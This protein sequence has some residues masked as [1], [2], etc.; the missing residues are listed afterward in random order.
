MT[1]LFC[2]VP[3]RRKQNGRSPCPRME[4]GRAEAMRRKIQ[5]TI[6]IVENDAS[7]AKRSIALSNRSHLEAI[8][9]DWQREID[10]SIVDSRLQT[11]SS[12]DRSTR[13][14][15]KSGSSK[16]PQNS[17]EDHSS[18]K[19]SILVGESTSW[20]FFFCTLKDHAQL[21]IMHALHTERKW[22]GWHEQCNGVWMG[23]NGTEA[24]P[25]FDSYCTYYGIIA[26]AVSTQNYLYHAHPDSTLLQTARFIYLILVMYLH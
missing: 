7:K 3:F 2:S 24:S 22:N 16:L 20:H 13:S 25:F 6:P 4:T 17:L 1:L 19:L 11:Q 23:R 26:V 21:L 10:R 15:S 12:L 5:S 8:R 18:I 14:K 9:V